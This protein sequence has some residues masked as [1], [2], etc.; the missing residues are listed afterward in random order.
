MQPMVIFF[1]KTATWTNNDKITPHPRVKL[2]H[3]IWKLKLLPKI[4][5]FVWKLIKDK[6]PT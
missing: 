1:V 3:Y 2:L 6:I 4:K 5:T